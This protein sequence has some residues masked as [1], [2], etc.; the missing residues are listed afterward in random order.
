VQPEIVTYSPPNDLY[1]HNN[2]YQVVNL[3]KKNYHVHEFLLCLVVNGAPTT[4]L[5]GH[6]GYFEGVLDL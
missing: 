6:Q 4:K 3:L 1:F 2:N 5:G